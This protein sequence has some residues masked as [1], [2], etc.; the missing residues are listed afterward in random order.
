M[1]QSPSRDE[2]GTLGSTDPRDLIDTGQVRLALRGGL[3]SRLSKNY[4]HRSAPSLLSCAAGSE[5]E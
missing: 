3:R 5:A 4:S 1:A 2:A